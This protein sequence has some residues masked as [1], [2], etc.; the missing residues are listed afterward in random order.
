MEELIAIWNDYII[1]RQALMDHQIIRTFNNPVEDFSEWLVAKYMNR[2]LAIN[3][4]QIDYDVETAEKYVQVKSIA[5]APNNPN[6]YIVTTKDR[7]NQL[8][9]NYAF[10][11]FDN[12]LPTDIYI[13]N[14]DYVRDYPRSQVKR[15]NL[16]EICGVPDTTIAT[17]SVR[18][19]L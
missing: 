2:Q 7:E 10:V 3:V 18:R 13:V 1:A 9:T 16:N 11:F 19:Q 6:G 17:V 14:A 4:N 5:K 15:Q 8:A 12:Y